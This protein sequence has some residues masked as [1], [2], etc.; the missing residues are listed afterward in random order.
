MVELEKSNAGGAASQAGANYQSGVAAL[1]GLRLLASSSLE[2]PFGLPSDVR[3]TEIRCQT[4]APVDD[5]NL[6]T[7]AGG[8]IFVQ[9]KT[10]VPVV[11][12]L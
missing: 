3:L 1:Y 4:E 2:P 12:N 10:N 9:V 6:R 11:S 8:Y 5:V 7:S